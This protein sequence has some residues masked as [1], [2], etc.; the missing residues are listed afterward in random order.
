MAADGK[1]SVGDE[2]R[3]S[4]PAFE[5][6]TKQHGRSNSFDGVRSDRVFG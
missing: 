5:K 1:T 2:M 4:D 3:N 6:R